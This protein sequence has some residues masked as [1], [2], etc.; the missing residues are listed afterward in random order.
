MDEIIA[1]VKAASEGP[2]KG[3]LSFTTDEVVSTDFVGCEY[4][5]IVDVGACAYAP[6]L[7]SE[8]GYAA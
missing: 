4:S 3:I 6:R 5:S 7:N 8:A 1:A 2:M